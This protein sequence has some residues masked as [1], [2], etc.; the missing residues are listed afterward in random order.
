MSFKW[1][2]YET[3]LTLSKNVF[4][5]NCDGKL[6]IILCVLSSILPII[7]CAKLENPQIRLLINDDD[8]LQEKSN[9]HER[10]GPAADDA[11]QHDKHS[12]E[13]FNLYPSELKRLSYET[14][15]RI[16]RDE[17]EPS[18]RR[19]ETEMR[20]YQKRSPSFEENHQ[21]MKR[22]TTEK[23]T[24]LNLSRRNL[25]EFLFTSQTLKLL[26][27]VSVLNLAN[28]YLSNINIARL[29]NIT[30]L[31]TLNLQNN[32]FTSIP[33]SRETSLLS[34][35][36]NNN[37]IRSSNLSA[38][39][40]LRNLFLAGN[41]IE[42]LSSIPLAMLKNLECL[43]L[44]NNL[45]TTISEASL[46]MERMHNLKDLNLAYNHLG[47]IYRET[48]YNLLSLN[49]LL[50]SHNNITD[51]DYET[52]LALPNLQFL[53]LS[54]NNLQGK[55]IRALQGLTGLVALNIAF[56]S[57]IGGYMQEFVASWSLKELD[58][59][60]TGLCQIPAALAQSVR[61]LKLTH[62]WL[63]VSVINIHI[64]SCSDRDTA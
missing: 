55:S 9:L 58:A 2:I 6:I 1:Q 5:K 47:C 10:G 8:L 63:K 18:Y 56:N 37:F 22:S 35:N 57:G 19:E 50:L 25:A 11:I 34:L 43:D 52:F 46:F 48:F 49:T 59:S 27:N 38:N 39:I 31:L 23:S 62:N 14:I 24:E 15:H 29:D 28:N 13:H 26:N 60:G 3:R 7:R 53:D 33:L 30:S 32:S 61:S 17:N 4:P 54:F 51:I 64:N 20:Y 21:L 40:Y 12:G 36:L 44:S 16:L 45:L 42:N 41:R